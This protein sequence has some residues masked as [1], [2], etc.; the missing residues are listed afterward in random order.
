MYAW[1]LT[2]LSP[3]TLED[4]TTSHT[5]GPDLVLSCPSFDIEQHFSRG[6]E[7]IE[8]AHGC[9]AFGHSGLGG[10]TAF[11]DPVHHLAFAFTTTTPVV[12]PPGLD[13]RARTLAESVH[14]SLAGRERSTGGRATHNGRR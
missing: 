4:L 9:S 5:S 12:G 13:S 7:V 10:T 3:R 11:A 6:F 1:L 2:T 8:P 14:R